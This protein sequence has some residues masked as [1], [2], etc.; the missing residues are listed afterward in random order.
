MKKTLLAAVIL[1]TTSNIALADSLVIGAPMPSFADKW[2]SYLFEGV[3][4]FDNK[5]DDVVI[6]LTDANE[7]PG[8]ML[9]DVDNFIDSGVD[10]LLVVPTD[11][12]IVKP[13]ASKANRAGI[14][15]VIVN[16]VPDEKTM[17]KIDAYV[18]SE[19][20]QAGILQA[21]SVVG[22]LDGRPAHVALLLG[23]LGHEAQINRTE[24][25]KQVFAKYPNIKIVAE[26]EGRWD[27]AKALQIVED[28][29]QAHPEINVIVAN[30][31]EMAIGALLAA[32]KSGKTDA[33]L[34][35]SGV[36]ATPD[37]LEYL[38]KG[39]DTTVFQSAK[40]QGFGGAEIAYKLAKGQKV[41][42]MNWIDFELVDKAQKDAYLLKY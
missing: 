12:S 8:K 38:G 9:N 36:D 42:K 34:I 13:I 17:Q 31:D 11:V 7:D 24:G 23:A 19:S 1:T 29:L 33:D 6:K 35:I 16:R 41:K 3:R 5:H 32:R 18:G 10:A 30:N 20:I 21:E 40:G 37:A 28:L 22:L 15:L 27:R 39:L 14:P 4:D 26:Q 25:N 2:M